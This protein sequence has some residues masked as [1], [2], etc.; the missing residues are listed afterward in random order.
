MKTIAMVMLC[1][2]GTVT[3]GPT[4]YNGSFETG[5]APGVYT[6]LDG[7]SA[8]IGAWTVV[9]PAKAIDYIGS[10]WTASDGS[11]SLDLNG[12]FQTGGIEQTI[13]TEAGQ[14]YVVSFDLAGNPNQQG[15][16][17]MQVSTSDGKFADYEFDTT[18][19]D[20]SNMGWEQRWFAFTAGSDAT[21]LRFASTMQGAWGPAL[22]N[23]TVAV[24]VP[25]ALFLGGLGMLIVR[26]FRIS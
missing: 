24:P 8:A 15:L 9:G 17:T 3:A 25:G 21:T 5:L 18:G 6:P 1:L 11:R 16:K 13:A 10:Y 26:R 22:D 4:L 14:S 2:V 12:Y 7:G 19:H 23:V 20:N